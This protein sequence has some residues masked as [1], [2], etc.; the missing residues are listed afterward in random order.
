MPFWISVAIRQGR[1]IAVLGC[2]VSQLILLHWPPA[3]SPPMLAQIYTGPEEARKAFLSRVHGPWESP[4]PLQDDEIELTG[5]LSRTASSVWT[6]FMCQ[7]FFSYPSVTR[8]Q[9]AELRV[10]RS[11]CTAHTAQANRW[12]RL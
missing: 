9:V 10:R 8:H 11:E 4:A 7:V 1:E 3:F 5:S 2:R 6:A 12:A